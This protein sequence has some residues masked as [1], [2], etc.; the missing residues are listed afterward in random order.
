MMDDYDD[1]CEAIYGMKIGRGSRS[2]RE[3]PLQSNFVHRKSR[4]I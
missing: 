1:K 3:K 2:T 4:M